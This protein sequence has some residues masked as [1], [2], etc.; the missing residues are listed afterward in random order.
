MA[1]TGFTIGGDVYE[2]VTLADLDTDERFILYEYSR[3]RQEDFLPEPGETEDAT[4]AK[5]VELTKHP[6]FW[7][8]LWHCA[9]RR[10]HPDKDFAAIRAVIGKCKFG[11]VMATLAPA[12]DEE[13]D[14]PL[15]LT[16]GPQPPSA[17]GSLDNEQQTGPSTPPPGN[18]STTGSDSPGSDPPPTTVS[19]LD[20][21]SISVHEI[22]AA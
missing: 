2:E 12:E 15:G 11:Q 16:S 3:L 6:G 22:S 9:Y 1:D 10:R 7:P 18:G 5:I 19:R 4:L 20:T 13:A 14:L 17:S 8:A 21:S